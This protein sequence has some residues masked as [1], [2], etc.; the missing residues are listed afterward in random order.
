VRLWDRPTRLRHIA[1]CMYAVA[2][3]IFLLIMGYKVIHWQTF[4][5]RDV[6]IM[7]DVRYIS[8]RQVEAVIDETARGSF[9][10]VNVAEV[11][12]NLQRLPWV[13]SVIVKRR[14]PTMLD[15]YFEEHHPVARWAK[16]GFINAQGEVFEATAQSGLDQLPIWSASPGSEKEL[17]NGQSMV[18][19]YLLPLGLHVK[20]IDLSPRHA[21]VFVLDQGV[22]V[23][24]GRDN[25]EERLRRFA[26]A[27]RNVLHQRFPRLEYVDLRYNTGFVVK[28]R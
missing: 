16:G 9:F 8:Q 22:K 23:F 21:W 18:E 7:G 15:I 28:Q 25:V 24:V 17:M 27:H 11:R 13:R 19:R 26:W 6:R 12:E 4:A 2:T 5:V 1:F 3:C 10:A 14:W 20:G